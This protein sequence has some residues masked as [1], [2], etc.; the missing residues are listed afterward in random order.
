MARALRRAG[1][2]FDDIA[3]IEINEAFA[4]FVLQTLARHPG[5]TTAGGLG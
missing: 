4:S 1:L 3:V 2:G 5:S